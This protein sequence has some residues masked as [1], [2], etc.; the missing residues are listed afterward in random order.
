M[1]KKENIIFLDIDGVLG[2]L[3]NGYSNLDIY[4]INFL[5]WLCET[6]DFKI[7]II[8]TWRKYTS[9]DVF[10]NIF[11]NCLHPDWRTSDLQKLN[12]GKH[13][14]L[15]EIN[16]WLSEH[17]VD[18]YVY[19]DDD[20]IDP[21][22]SNPIKIDTFLGLTYYTFKEICEYLD[23]PYQYKSNT[24]SLYVHEDM[25]NKNFQLIERSLPHEDT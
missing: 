7:V 14:R 24:V 1:N 18:K 5:I 20:R 23:V 9:E 19:L 12:Y 2:T 10:K 11:K 25:F 3:K 22:K 21:E 6:H 4:S 17:Q 8:S 15:E 16:K 13:T